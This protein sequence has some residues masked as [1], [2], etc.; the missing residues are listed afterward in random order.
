MRRKPRRPA[1]LTDEQI[2][3][4]EGGSDVAYNS[5]LAHTSA[6]ALVPMGRN[7]IE[8]D[9]GVRERI[10]ELVESEGIDV[11][12]EAWVSSPET[13]LPG[14]LWRGFLLHEW[15][16]RDGAVVEKRFVSACDITRRRGGGGER[17]VEQTPSPS[18][19]AQQWAAVFSGHFDGYFDEV[20]RDSAR[21]TDMLAEITPIWIDSDDD[22]LATLVTRRDRAME[23]TSREFRHAGELAL[24][25][26]LE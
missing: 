14:I 1:Q 7:H 25:G 11:L 18:V 23:V 16:R 21:L 17:K 12:A 24:N 8:Y 13:T 5:E 10:L 22:E 4:I 26:G 20:L 15:V 19:V 3:A 6:Q 9:A 2:E